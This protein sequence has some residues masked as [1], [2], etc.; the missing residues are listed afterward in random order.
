[1]P[2]QYKFNRDRDEKK[3]EILDLKNVIYKIKIMQEKA[4]TSDLN[5]Q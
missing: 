2:E 1:M 3:I 4:L 5:K